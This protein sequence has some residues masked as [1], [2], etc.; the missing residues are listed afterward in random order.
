M[1]NIF[2]TS[3]NKQKISEILKKTIG[4]KNAEV[5][6]LIPPWQEPKGLVDGPASMAKYLMSNNYKIYKPRAIADLEPVP[7]EQVFAG[8]NILEVPGFLEQHPY[9]ELPVGKMEFLPTYRP[10]HYSSRVPDQRLLNQ[11]VYQAIYNVEGQGLDEQVRK[12]YEVADGYM[13]GT[14]T[15]QGQLQRLIDMRAIRRG[16]RDS[17]D[18]K[19]GKNKPNGVKEVKIEGTEY[20]GKRTTVFS[21]YEAMALI[22]EQTLPI[23]APINLAKDGPSPPLLYLP[24]DLVMESEGETLDEL[25]TIRVKTSAGLPFVKKPGTK[26]GEVLAESIAIADGF[27]L[28]LS[29]ALKV[30]DEGKQVEAITTLLEDYWY[31]GCGLLFPKAERYK[32]S[33]WLKKTRNIWSSPTPTHILLGMITDP[34]M[35]NNYNNCINT[36]TPSLAKFNPFEGLPIIAELMMRASKGDS[37]ELI[38]ADNIYMFYEE[39]D[40]TF[41][42]F[43]LD[44]EKGEANATPEDASAVAYYMLTRGWLDESGAPAFSPTWAFFAM[45]IAPLLIVDPTCLIMN[46]QIPF[47]GQGSGNSWTFLINHVISSKLWNE[48]GRQGKPRPGSD[49][50]AAL[51]KKM[52]VNIKIEREEL[53]MPSQLKKCMETT[54]KSGWLQ[55]ENATGPSVETI[56]VVNLDL[57]GFS[58]AYSNKLG[59]FVPVLDEERLWPSAVYPKKME[60]RDYKDQPHMLAAYDVIR[61]N[62]VR[63]MGGWAYRGLDL[64]CQ[65]LAK[66]QL[67]KL[68]E[69]YD[70]KHFKMEL[71]KMSEFGDLFEDSPTVDLTVEMNEEFLEMLNRERTPKPE[72]ITEWV[73]NP[74]LRNSHAVRLR[75]TPEK[76]DV[77]LKEALTRGL[78]VNA[79]RAKLSQYIK[80]MQERP[81]SFNYQEKQA[82]AYMDTALQQMRELKEAMYLPYDVERLKIEPGFARNQEQA[83]NPVVAFKLKATGSGVVSH[84]GAMAKKTDTRQTGVMRSANARKMV[85]K[86]EKAKEAKELLREA[87]EAYKNK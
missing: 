83:Y 67:E 39:E 19:K 43:S 40:G 44:L 17:A 28:G 79:S 18:P 32:R 59:K 5:I 84:T 23:P 16:D 3:E 86:R 34:I 11:M 60:N 77:K 54:P 33:D 65:V 7:T 6:T 21:G 20:D 30:T 27:M 82:L 85:K 78:L 36:E 87:Q 24:G 47:P 29:N 14:G 41:T 9:L 75:M 25:P 2:N 81:K 71:T 50:W 22:L 26:K 10:T 53:D 62:A 35:R 68:T 13:Y 56:P 52:G 58:A 61:Y 4:D 51:C 46:Q 63:Y 73:Y 45:N 80:K 70:V 38:Y 1:S 55:E 64:S 72:N 76:L 69:N 42:W 37:F 48:W 31:L 66:G 15:Y 49:E 74:I 12:A 57:L 8:Y